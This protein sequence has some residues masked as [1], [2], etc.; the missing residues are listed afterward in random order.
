MLFRSFAKVTNEIVEEE[1]EE[2]KD[3]DSRGIRKKHHNK[4]RKQVTQR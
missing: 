4:A 1:E 3:T 2:E